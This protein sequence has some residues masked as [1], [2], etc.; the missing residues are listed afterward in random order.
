M[1]DYHAQILRYPSVTMLMPKRTINMFI[2]FA[3]ILV[4]GLVM[5]QDTVQIPDEVKRFVDNG[6]IPIALESGD[7]NADGREDFV[8]VTSDVVPDDAPY[9]EGAGART[10]LVLA[11]GAD[12]SLTSEARNDL[13]ALCKRCG[14]AFG[15]PFEGV[16]IKGTRFTVMNY[17]GSA[18]RWAYHYTFDYSRR[19]R[20][21]QLVRVEESNFNT[22]DPERTRKL[23]IYTPPRHFG[24]ITF[25][26]F[27]PDNFQGKGKKSSGKGAERR[28]KPAIARGL[29]RLPLWLGLEI[30]G[31][32]AIHED[33]QGGKC[34]TLGNDADRV[35]GAKRETDESI[36]SE[37]IDRTIDPSALFPAK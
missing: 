33:G 21:W 1:Q 6:R 3:I 7:L 37:W 11:R 5:G 19:D 17:G 36:I 26:D 13:V 23:R 22:L 15:D 35:S 2:F 14:G 18:D 31:N 25:S 30:D 34:V 12:G 28:G 32:V 10:V 24:L 8:L 20:T 4:P 9:E 16:V 27:D 29:L